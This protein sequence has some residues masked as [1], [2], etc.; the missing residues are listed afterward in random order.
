MEKFRKEYSLP[1]RILTIDLGEE[2]NP[3]IAKNVGAKLRQI[4]IFKPVFEKKLA[5]FKSFE[6]NRPISNLRL[7]K[8]VTNIKDILVDLKRPVQSLK[9]NF[10]IDFVGQ[11]QSKEMPMFQKSVF[12]KRETKVSRKST[13]FLKSADLKMFAQEKKKNWVTNDTKPSYPKIKFFVNQFSAKKNTVS[14][15]IFNP[16]KSSTKRQIMTSNFLRE[17]L[18]VEKFEMLRKVYLG[19]HQSFTEIESFLSESQR[20]LIKLF[21]IAFDFSTPTTQESGVSG[22]KSFK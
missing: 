5:S 21:P 17:K 16:D 13:D 14:S 4:P 22:S 19:Q 20:C 1:R 12:L 3:P 18:G 6:K 7:S 8:P 2:L 10:G 11:H 9:P 15:L